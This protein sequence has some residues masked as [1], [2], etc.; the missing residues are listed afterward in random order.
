[1]TKRPVHDPENPEWTD[2]DFAGAVSFDQAF[3]DVADSIRRGRGRP[4]LTR[5]KKQVSLRLDQDVIDCF[6]ADGPGWQSRMNEAL[7]KAAG[8]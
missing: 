8:L 2:E 5:P 3:P 6:K 1:M 4:P 7:R